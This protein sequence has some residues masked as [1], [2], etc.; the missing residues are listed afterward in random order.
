MKCQVPPSITS[1]SYFC[2]CHARA[3]RNVG[4]PP[5]VS[6]PPQNVP[7]MLVSL[8]KSAP[9]PNNVPPPLPNALAPV[10]RL[11]APVMLIPMQASGVGMVI[12]PRL[13]CGP[14]QVH[15]HLV[16]V[17]DSVAGLSVSVGSIQ[18]LDH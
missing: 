9:P 12:Q 5:Y 2:Y 17:Q 10:E 11:L 6:T 8:H 15:S 1:Y 4:V 18:A 16:G 14:I 3:W 7:G 13:A